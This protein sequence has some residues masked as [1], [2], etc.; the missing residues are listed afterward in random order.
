MKLLFKI[1]SLFINAEVY[2]S[3]E[4]PNYFFR[5]DFAFL[6]QWYAMIFL[7]FH[8]LDMRNF[9]LLNRISVLCGVC[10]LLSIV[11]VCRLTPPPHTHQKKRKTRTIVFTIVFNTKIYYFMNQQNHHNNYYFYFDQLHQNVLIK[12]IRN[13]NGTICAIMCATDV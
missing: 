10:V 7:V 8:T 5:L 4:I 1:V 6:F 3:V 9:S 12:K 2:I 11:C 13:G